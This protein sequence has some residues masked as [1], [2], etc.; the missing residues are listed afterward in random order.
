MRGLLFFFL[1]LVSGCQK[2]FDDRYA[3]TE[4]QLKA[5]AGRLD[6]EM[7]A[8]AKKEPGDRGGQGR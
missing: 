3:E 2:D 5:D 8:E 4:K 1:L 6:R 7:A